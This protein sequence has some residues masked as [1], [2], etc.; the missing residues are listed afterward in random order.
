MKKTLKILM[1][2]ILFAVVLTIATSVNAAVNTFTPA[3][4][5]KAV[6]DDTKVKMEGSTLKILNDIDAADY[7]ELAGKKLLLNGVNIDTATGKSLTAT[8]VE[9]RGDVVLSGALPAAKL[10]VFGTLYAGTNPTSFEVKENGKIYTATALT[11]GTDEVSFELKDAKKAQPLTAGALTEYKFILVTED[12]ANANVKVTFGKPYVPGETTDATVI[13]A[14]KVYYVDVTVKYNNE[15]LADSVWTAALGKDDK[16]PAFDPNCTVSKDGKA[17]EITIADKVEAGKSAKAEV[18]VTNT[19]VKASVVLTIG[20]VKAEDPTKPEDPAKPEDPVKPS[21]D[22]KK[23]DLDD[24][25]AVATGDHIIPA[26][27]LL[28]VVVVANVV[29]FAKSK[30]N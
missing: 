10:T 8:G 25:A 12:A 3:E 23:G 17:L 22:D 11:A 7:T 16:D 19:D 9:V 13:E 29:Y 26:T 14:K 2:I 1:A 15:E 6:D 4:L 28:A 27:A 5:V 21:E 20:E 18:V 24:A 30:N